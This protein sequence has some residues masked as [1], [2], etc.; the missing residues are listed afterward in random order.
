MDTNNTESVSV[1]QSSRWKSWA[2]GFCLFVG[3]NYLSFQYYF[4]WKRNS[5]LTN[6]PSDYALGLCLLFFFGLVISQKRGV[7]SWAFRAYRVQLGSLAA[8]LLVS[9]LRSIPE[10]GGALTILSHRGWLYVLFL[11]L[12]YMLVGDDYTS[13]RFIRFLSRLSVL[14]GI[15]A[16]VYAF[17][18][19]PGNLA[20]Y[21]QQVVPLSSVFLL[22]HLVRILRDHRRNEIPLLLFH[23][24]VIAVS[25]TRSFWVATVV[26]LL[27]GGV[28]MAEHIRVK[29]VVF[30]GLAAIALMWGILSSGLMGGAEDVLTSRVTGGME[31][32]QEGQGTYALRIAGFLDIWDYLEES[33]TFV[34]MMGVGDLHWKAPR[35][36]YLLG[37]GR[38]L[39]YAAVAYE[40]YGT[41]E[42]AY[43]ENTIANA[44]LA[45]GLVGSSVLWFLVYYPLAFRLIRDSKLIVPAGSSISVFAF[46]YGLY[47]IGQ[48]A[49]FFFGSE[50]KGMELGF[51]MLLLGVVLRVAKTQNNTA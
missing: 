4:D 11:P 32:V 49:T 30:S 19:Q 15:F 47:M 9:F 7:V 12:G 36:Q 3:T 50:L 25:Q 13:T 20:R 28:M 27:V 24:V 43:V 21:Y 26:S 8:L 17:T 51:T 22:Y 48:P 45:F 1:Q 16:L 33:G 40:Q 29:R 31:D 41:E 5:P 10:Q 42:T 44:L 14:S 23:A 18:F 38:V 2:V 6:T 34:R 39:G 37:Y 46:A 35:M